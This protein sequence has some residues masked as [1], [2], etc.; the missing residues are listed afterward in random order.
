ML[1][2]SNILDDMTRKFEAQVENVIR[3]LRADEGA[4]EM[5]PAT[6]L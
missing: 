2:S 1:K 5:P 4:R 3:T 6:R